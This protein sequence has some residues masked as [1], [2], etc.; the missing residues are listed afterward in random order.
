MS[1]PPVFW[2][3]LLALVK[4]IEEGTNRA[5]VN[6]IFLAEAHTNMLC[7][8]AENPACP[9]SWQQKRSSWRGQLLHLASVASPAAPGLYHFNFIK[10]VGVFYILQILDL[11]R[12]LYLLRRA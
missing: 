5:K 1:N 3:A 10:D 4:H 9:T 8:H 12:F 7:Y 11:L 2:S 6:A